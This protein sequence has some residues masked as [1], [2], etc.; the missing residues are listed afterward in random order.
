MKLRLTCDAVN[1]RDEPGEIEVDLCGLQSSLSRLDLSLG[2][3]HGS[4]R[5][6]I[7]LN[8]IIQILL[9]GCLLSG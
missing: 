6:K 9:A 5:G 7:V 8:G 1:G 2:C 4:L 3:C